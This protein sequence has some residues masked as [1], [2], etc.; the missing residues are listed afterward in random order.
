MQACKP[1][2]GG[3]HRGRAGGRGGVGASGVMDASIMTWQDK[4][5]RKQH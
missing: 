1:G 3:A 2:G 4:G 5:K